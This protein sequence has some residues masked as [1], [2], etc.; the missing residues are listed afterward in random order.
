MTSLANS[1]QSL[2]QLIVQ[3]AA[4]HCD[5]EDGPAVT[6]GRRAL[7]SVNINVALKWVSADAADEV[8]TS[9][10]EAR[11]AVG[12]LAE[13]AARSFLETL[14]RVHRAG[15]SVEFDGIK[16][17][18]TALPAQ[19][20]EADKALDEGTMEPLRGLIPDDRW[21]ELERRFRDALAKKNFDMDDL[22]AAR[23]YV[24]AYVKYFK[25]AEGDDDHFHGH[26][27]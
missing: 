27:R 14:A 23:Q 2:R 11:A 18:G 21:S 24:D 25:Y 6:D 22:P 7:A 19:V 10:E 1:A 15:E 13:R 26:H 8:R 9:F 20:V 16:P 17:H 4:A 12:D 5:T 3:P